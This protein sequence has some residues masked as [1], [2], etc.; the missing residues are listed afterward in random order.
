[1]KNSQRGFVPIVVALVLVALGGGYFG[2]KY[3]STA[4]LVCWPYCPNMTDQDRADIK[5]TMLEAETANWQTHENLKMGY[6]VSFPASYHVVRENNILNFN[7]ELFE[8]GNLDGVKIQIQQEEAMAYDLS[9]EIGE[10]QTISAIN[11]YIKIGK[12]EDRQTPIVPIS[13]NNIKYK[14]QVLSGPGGAFEIYYAFSSKGQMFFKILV[15]GAQNDD[16]NVQ[17]ILSTFKFT[18]PTTGDTTG[19]RTYKSEKYG[20][21]FSYPPNFQITTDKIEQQYIN[22]PRGFNWYR[23]EMTNP[24]VLEMPTLRFEIDPDGYGPF[25]PDKT[26]QMTETDSGRLSI[27]SVS[28]IKSENSNDGKTLIIPSLLQAD[29]GHNYYWQFSFNSGGQD[30]ESLFR[31]ILSTFKFISPTAGVLNEQKVAVTDSWQTYK[32]EKY[33]FE[34]KYPAL[35]SLKQEGEIVKLNHSISYKHADP[36]DFKGDAPPLDNLADFDVSFQI[37]GKSPKDYIQSIQWPNWDYV[38]KNPFQF[39]GFSGFK[40]SPGVEGCGEDIYY[41]SVATNRTLVIRRP[42]VSE[43]N[44]SVAGREAFLKL[45]GIILPE[46]EKGLFNQIF[47]SLKFTK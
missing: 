8:R 16:D 31:Q 21:E 41:L 2:Y 27:D 20:F 38:S 14:N 9:N 7:D 42:F 25:F 11:N 18:Q 30:L 6:S 37:I 33:G 34:F 15:Y 47:S 40:I 3:F 43:L 29:S 28:E 35:L 22:H 44:G 46:E 10:G 12:G 23:V 5:K 32:N 4:K 36:C 26:Y 1:M 19:W 17:K 45:H 13:L 24:S 39:G